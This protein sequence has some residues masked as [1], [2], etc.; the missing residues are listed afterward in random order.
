MFLFSLLL[1]PKQWIDD[2]NHVNYA[3]NI[4]ILFTGNT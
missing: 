2:N 1:F 4:D 3:L